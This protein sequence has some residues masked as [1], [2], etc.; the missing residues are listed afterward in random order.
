[1]EEEIPFTARTMQVIINTP[2]N[3]IP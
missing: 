3:A 2:T 1:V